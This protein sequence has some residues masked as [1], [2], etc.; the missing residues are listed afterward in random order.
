M[1]VCFVD[2]LAALSSSAWTATESGGESAMRQ[3]EGIQRAA[4]ERLLW[5]SCCGVIP[6]APRS[7]S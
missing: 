1:S 7:R 2:T 3:H 5:M 4:L 6:S